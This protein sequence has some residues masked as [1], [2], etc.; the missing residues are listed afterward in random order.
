M[1]SVA[2]GWEQRS[3]L[4]RANTVTTAASLADQTFDYVRDFRFAA[5]WRKLTRCRLQ[6]IVG[7]GTA[8]LVLAARLSENSSV[9]VAVIEAGLS[10]DAVPDQV[11]PPAQAYFGG[12]F[13]SHLAPSDAS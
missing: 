12:A 2:S 9:T 6:V 8:G 10:G 5:L 13:S 11:L 4:K 1:P 7:G 3:H